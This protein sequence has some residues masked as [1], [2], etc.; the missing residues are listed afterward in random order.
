[1]DARRFDVLTR[2]LSSPDTRRRVLG[3]LA[4][5][6]L[7][8]GLVTFLD[9]D[10]AEGRKRR[11]R[12][13]DRHR[14]RKGKAD[15]KR[16]KRRCKPKRKAKVCAGRCGVVK[17]RKTC[18]KRIDCGPCDCDPPCGECFTCQGNGDAPGTCVPRTGAPC[19]QQ[20]CKDGVLQP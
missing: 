6:P 18:G 16:R 2:T 5:A 14:R 12:R 20:T 19:G 8:G 3:V 17:N 7:L 11:E 15:S 10:E 13:K 1:M 9:Q 4:S